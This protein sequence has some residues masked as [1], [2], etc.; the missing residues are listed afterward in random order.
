MLKIPVTPQQR[1]QL[2]EIAEL[3]S[4]T[5]VEYLLALLEREIM[6]IG[7]LQE[8]HPHLFDTGNN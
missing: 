2:E 3:H 1:H 8:R 4:L 6:L 5:L 7:T